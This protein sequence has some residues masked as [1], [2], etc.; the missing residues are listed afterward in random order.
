[1]PWFPPIEPTHHKWHALIANDALTETLPEV[2]AET[3]IIHRSATEMNDALP[4]FSFMHR[5]DVDIVRHGDGSL[6]AHVGE[7]REHPFK[8]FPDFTEGDVVGSFRL[9]SSIR[10]WQVKHPKYEPLYV[11]EP[12]RKPSRSLRQRLAGWWA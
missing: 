4:G 6:S 5:T 7:C 2:L 3:V 1:M 9:Y 8:D 11:S 12:E 10:Q